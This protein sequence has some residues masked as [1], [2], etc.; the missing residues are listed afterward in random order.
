MAA[1]SAADPC[2]LGRLSVLEIQLGPCLRLELNCN[3][4]YLLATRKQA[5]SG[6]AGGVEEQ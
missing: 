6:A 2:R 5:G 1:A 4:P 3:I